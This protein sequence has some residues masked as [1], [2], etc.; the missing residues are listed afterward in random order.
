[1][2]SETQ[3]QY[4]IIAKLK[5]KGIT[6]TIKIEIKGNEVSLKGM[7]HSYEAKDEIEQLIVQFKEVTSVNN[8]LALLNEN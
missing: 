3:L 4:K 7:V 1:M 2:L 5:E 8:E 6:E